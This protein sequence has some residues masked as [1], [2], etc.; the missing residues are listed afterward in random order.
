M[1]SDL[2]RSGMDA[3]QCVLRCIRNSPLQSLTLK[4]VNSSSIRTPHSVPL[5]ILWE[6]K[7]PPPLRRLILWGYRLKIGA[8]REVCRKFTQLEVLGVHL[9]G[10]S[11]VGIQFHLFRGWSA[12]RSFQTL[13]CLVFNEAMNLHTILDNQS[14][15][16]R[17]DAVRVLLAN[18]K[19][20]RVYLDHQRWEVGIIIFLI[21]CTID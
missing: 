12:D 2:G 6:N 3:Q 14:S 13:A 1:V 19:L 18:T 16:I 7:Q 15:A 20:R 21:V 4:N 17:R 11:P 8:I 10:L 5:E 9:S